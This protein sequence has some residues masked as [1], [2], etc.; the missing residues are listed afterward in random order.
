M[1]LRISL[2]NRLT[3]SYGLFISLALGILALAVNQFTG[4][5]FN[6]LVRDNIAR[7][8]GE[9]ARTLGDQWRPLEDRFD[10]GAVEAMGMYFVHQGYIVSLEDAAGQTVWD[11]RF[12]DMEQ[13]TEVINSIAWRMENEYRLDGA[14]RRERF[15]VLYNG[16]TVG[17]AAIETYGPFFYS[18]TEAGFLASVN[19]LFT[20]AAALL[21]LLSVIISALVSRTIA[22][23]VLKAGAAARNIAALHSGAFPRSGAPVRIRDNY[24]TAEL[25]DLSRSVNELA[26]ELEAGERRQK[27]LTADIAHE[28]RT[29]LTCLQGNIEA[30]ID[31]VFNCDRERLESCHGEII[32]LA[33]LVQD[34]NTLTSL[35]WENLVLDKT[36]FDLSKLLRVTAD[37][38]RAAARE[39][40]ITLNLELAP[41]LVSA[42]YNRL[43]QVFINLLSNAVKYTDRGGV[44]VTLKQEKP[45]GTPRSPVTVYIADTGIGIPEEDRPYIFDRFYRS[46]KSRARST[47]GAGIGLAIAAAITAAHGGTITVESVVKPGEAQD[48]ALGGGTKSPGVAPG[49]AVFCVRL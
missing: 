27:Q 34:L 22:S 4:K 13:C 20:V 39:K 5:V 30:M 26:A 40:G 41:C 3:L 2:Q 18:E 48:F 42:D 35:E 14:F 24:R 10:A 12:C 23:P 6:R 7:T 17:A 28:L 33:N 16:R 21:T 36:E 1:A 37:Q 32:R 44:T 11:A 29:P 31:G 47:G 43:K 15:P 25:A 19:R 38:F 46:D 45:S 49:G 9:I 8:S